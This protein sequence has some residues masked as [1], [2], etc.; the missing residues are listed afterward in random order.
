M[1]R[2]VV[3]Q[4]VNHVISADTCFVRG[5]HLKKGRSQWLSPASGAVRELHYGRIILDA[6]AEAVWFANDGHETGLICLT[7]RAQVKTC[8]STFSMGLYDSLYVPR[9]SEIEVASASAGNER[10]GCDLAEISAPVEHSYPLQFVPYADVKA[11]PG[12]HFKTGATSFERTVNVLIGKNVQ[13]GRILAGV[14]FSQ[15]GNWTSWPPH[16]HAE[17]LEEAYVYI[18]MPEPAWGMQF[19]YTDPKAPELAQVVR[20]GD[21][22]VMPA[23]YH[24]NVAAPGGSINFLWIMAAHREVE[25]RQFGVVNVQPEYASGESGL[26]SGRAAK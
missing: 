25:D 5:T 14:T 18:A 23:G 12:L 7:G 21:C 26:E 8:G 16:E 10:G 4:D 9:D 3:S 6:G 2:S 13:A 17:M 11:D 24:P 1:M 22:V 19:V 20:E 15:P